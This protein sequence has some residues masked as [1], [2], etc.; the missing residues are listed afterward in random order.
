MKQLYMNHTKKSFLQM[1]KQYFEE[2]YRTDLAVYQ[3]PKPIIA[4]LME[5]SWAVVLA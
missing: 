1:V 4:C 2:E 5:S 3:F